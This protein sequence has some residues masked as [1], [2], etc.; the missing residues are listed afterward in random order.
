MGSNGWIVEDL[1]SSR[2]LTVDGKSTH[3]VALQGTSDVW[4]G[5]EEAGVRVIFVAPGKTRSKENHLNPLFVLLPILAVTII[6]I[7]AVVVVRSSDNTTVV[8]VSPPAGAGSATPV[9]TAAPADYLDLAALK[10]A[11]VRIEGRFQLSAAQR[12]RVDAAKKDKGLD[13]SAP[14]LTG[15]GTIISRDGLILTNA[16][17]AT[18]DQVT[19]AG[20]DQLPPLE[21]L[22]V[23][24]NVDGSDEALTATDAAEVVVSDP[25][26]DLAVIRIKGHHD[27]PAAPIGNDQGVKAGDE[28]VV[29]GFPGIAGTDGVNVTRGVASSFVADKSLGTDRAWINTDAKIDPGNSGGLAANRDGKIVGVPTLACFRPFGSS[30]SSGPVSQ[31]NRIR[32]IDLA[33]P[34]I[35]AAE[36]GTAYDPVSVDPQSC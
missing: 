21:S 7:I 15:S 33:R 8:A 22:K 35:D 23:A 14:D 16:H 34:L 32:A 31:Q 29:L 3:Q 11:T 2:G 27:L 12:R 30:S 36:K 20:E 9:A 17:V 26:L 4:F 13:S 6:A 18:P 24:L 19:E 5:P 10:K 25:K 28:L 1:G